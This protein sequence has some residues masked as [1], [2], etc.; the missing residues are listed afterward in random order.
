MNIIDVTKTANRV[1]HLKA[2]RKD[3]L[4][5]VLSKLEKPITRFDGRRVSY[6]LETIVLS[7]EENELACVL[8]ND[9]DYFSKREINLFFKGKNLFE[10]LTF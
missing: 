1:G 7:K 6:Q 4:A 3:K 8:H 5:M 2:E 9:F 10:F